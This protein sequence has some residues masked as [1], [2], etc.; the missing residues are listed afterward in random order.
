MPI[1]FPPSGLG[2]SYQTSA[3]AGITVTGSATPHVMG[4]YTTII[5][6]LSYPTFGLAINVTGVAVSV[7]DTS[8]LM[9]ISIAP[10]GGGNEQII[11]PFLDVGAASLI[12]A[13]GGKY[14]F[15]PV[16]IPAG[17]AVRAQVQGVVANDQAAVI[18]HAYEHPPYGFTESGAIQEWTQ[19]G[20]VSANSRGTAV[21]S[22]LN[23]FGTEA[24]IT[25]STSRN[26]NWFHVGFS[27]GTNTNVTGGRYR[28]RLARDTAA[29]DVIGIWDFGAPTSAE[30][31]N[32]PFHTWPVNYPLPAGSALN[33]DVDGAAAEAVTVMVYAA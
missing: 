24:Q 31:I 12:G 6:P 22:A 16:Y 2:R 19:Y 4:A 7:T 10:S 21:T 25:A 32:G 17:K 30:D 13:A 15:F 11:I 33:I 1:V 18:A 3:K 9:N 26:H 28:V 8:M 5:D 23:A 20:A 27:Y 29:A 14:Y